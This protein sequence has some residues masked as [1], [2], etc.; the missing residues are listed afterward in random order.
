MKIARD[1]WPV[2]GM[3]AGTLGPVAAIGVLAGHPVAV[4]APAR[5]RFGRFVRG[6]GRSAS[7]PGVTAIV[8]RG[9]RL[10]RDQSSSA[11]P[12]RSVT[13]PAMRSTSSRPLSASSSGAPEE[14]T[15]T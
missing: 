1:G 8:A 9:S 13:A 10:T 6:P 11:A 7:L 12:S 15:V 3:A 5:T 14:T 4:H 2:V